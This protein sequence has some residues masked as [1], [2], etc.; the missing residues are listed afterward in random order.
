MSIIIFNARDP[1]TRANVHT[2]T[3]HPHLTPAPHTHTNTHK[4]V[5]TETGEKCFFFA[6]VHPLMHADSHASM[7][8]TIYP[9]VAKPK[10]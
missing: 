7:L 8:D 9:V 4:V 6:H 5:V 3:S 10:P 2:R 1:F